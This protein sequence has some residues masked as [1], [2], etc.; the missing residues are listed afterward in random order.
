MNFA[1]WPRKLPRP[2]RR[3]DPCGSLAL[4][5]EREPSGTPRATAEPVSRDL[6]SSSAMRCRFARRT[7]RKLR[8]SSLRAVKVLPHR[9]RPPREESRG[10]GGAP[11][12]PAPL[13]SRPLS[14]T[15]RA[16]TSAPAESD[17][18]GPRCARLAPVAPQ[19]TDPK[20]SGRESLN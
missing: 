3:N 14:A 20:G 17:R 9:R 12:I 8:A 2:C 16:A 10:D 4:T 19:R 5:T 15:L 1:S 7:L 18:W 13:P 11:V 6:L